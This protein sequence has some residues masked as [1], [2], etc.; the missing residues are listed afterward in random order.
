MPV[1]EEVGYSSIAGKWQSSPLTQLASCNLPG[2]SL[3]DFSLRQDE[4]HQYRREL[5]KLFFSKLVLTGPCEDEQANGQQ[6]TGCGDSAGLGHLHSSCTSRLG[7]GLVRR[8]SGLERH[9]TR[10]GALSP[11][12]Q[13]SRA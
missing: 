5:A 11:R 6:R 4:L 12:T 1:S 2:A 8:Q 7:Q 13:R 3:S 9:E 10:R